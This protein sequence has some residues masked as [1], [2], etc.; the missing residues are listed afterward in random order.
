MGELSAW[1][2]AVVV[3]VAVFLFGSQRLPELAR[4]IGGPARIL[5]AELRPDADTP[6]DGTPPDPDPR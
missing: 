5:T 1:H 4:G 3:L 2:W 6:R